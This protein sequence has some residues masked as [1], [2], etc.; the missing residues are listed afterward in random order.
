MENISW[1]GRVR[2]EELLQIV[3]KEINVLRTIKRRKAKL[4]GHI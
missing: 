4:I 3:N 1:T 2:N